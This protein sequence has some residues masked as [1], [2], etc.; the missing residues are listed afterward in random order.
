MMMISKIG[1][2]YCFSLLIILSYVSIIQGQGKSDFETRIDVQR[3]RGVMT[4]TG[5]LVN[6]TNQDLSLSYLLQLHH[7][8]ENGKVTSNQS[9]AFTAFANM[10]HQLSSVELNNSDK[11][12]Y[13]IKLEIFKRDSLLGSKML[14]SKGYAAA[15]EAL[16]KETPKTPK[17]KINAPIPT[18]PQQED[19]IIEPQAN[20]NPQ[21]K[22]DAV[23]DIE[24]DGLI[25]DQTRTKT[26]RD[27]YYNFYKN[28]TAPKGAKGFTITVK[29][30]PA[31]G[32]LA[33]I[34][35]QVDDY[36]LFKRFLMPRNDIIE[37]LAGQSINTVQT[38]LAQREQLDK[39]LESEDQA[40]DGIF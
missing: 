4:I 9:N 37:I 23:E 14:E 30:L 24:I 12:F 36:I 21:N 10:P 20:P 7:I 33:Q 16:K 11:D 17:Q 27:F 26:G 15:A 28:W 8:G 32:R 29:E 13:Q 22:V 25:I 34:V 38:Y 40:G 5:V 1:I 6:N 35:V 18:P 39:Q 2:K 19:K 31:R 3:D